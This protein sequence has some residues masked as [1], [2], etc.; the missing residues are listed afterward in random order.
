MV[1]AAA[2]LAQAVLPPAESHFQGN[3]GRTWRDADPAKFPLPLAPPPG[4]PNIVIVLLDDVGFGQFSVFGGGVPSPNMEKLAAAGLSYIRFHTAGI[5]SPTRAALLTGRNPHNVGFGLV[6]ELATGYD[7][8][9]GS[10]PRST[11]TIAEVLRQHGYATAMFGKNHNTPNWEGGPAGPFNH[12][13]TGQ[14]FDYFYGFNGWGVSN[15]QPLLYENTRPVPPSTDPHY[16]LN[17]DLVGRSI[18][19]MRSVKSTNPDKPFFL[20]VA[21]G[22]THAPH[23]A[24]RDWIEKFKGQFDMGWDRYRQLTFERQK[25]LGV[26]PADT[27]L[28]ARPG[29]IPAWDSL[30]AGQQRIDAHQMEVFA[31]FGAYTDYE[32]G[33]LL[34]AIASSPDADNTLILYVI[35]D[36]G[37]SAEGGPDGGVNEI[38]AANGLQGLPKFTPDIVA[39]LGGPKYNNH[40][41]MGWAWAMNTPFKYYKQ[42]VSHLGA[43]RNPLLV[44]WPARIKEKGGRRDQF[45]DVTDIAPT[46]LAA[47][48]IDIPTSVNGTAQKPMDGMSMLDTFTD[49]H[50]PEHRVTQYF[51]VFANRGIYDHGW[52]ASALL[53]ADVGNP[54]RASLD[55]DRVVWELY[56]LRKDFS[57]AEDLAAA[58]PLRLQQLKDLWWA[59][60]GK[61]NVL[62]LDWR[63]GE[64]LVGALRPNPSRGRTHFVFYPGMVGLP[65]SI[66]PNVHNRSWRIVARGK[67]SSRSAGM[68]IT[69]GGMSGG[70]AL[71]VQGGHVVFDYNYAEV[72][73]DHIVS[74]GTLPEDAMTIEARFAYDGK[75]GK[76]FGAGGTL[77]LWVDGKPIGAGHLDRTLSG[78][79]SIIDGLDIGADYG[80]P[81]SDDYPFP[82]P[83]NGELK[84]VS[85]DLE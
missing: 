31:A 61:N 40:F 37:A 28:T 62:P 27:R 3:T 25:K 58:Q 9:V 11:A 29:L 59:E 56:D 65:E 82:F 13:P 76:D 73:Y 8:Y 30:S 1:Y 45:L 85:I 72:R 2:S 51:E 32:I 53:T 54:N 44:S 4:A 42:V 77:S 17:A 36:N 71:Y 52:F 26:I 60:A 83:F 35:G 16:H 43:I 64:R 14:G 68:L 50:A 57:Q 63:A 19:W 7:G 81:V 47:A 10:I 5:C 20:Y 23:H 41:A 34:D 15:W 74:T 22:A 84:T 55:P 38:G 79:F 21:P 18:A 46:L 66:A 78:L 12:W 48:G 24:P 49:P 6:G 67:F 80:S 69:Q 33:R 75:S 70:W 39:S